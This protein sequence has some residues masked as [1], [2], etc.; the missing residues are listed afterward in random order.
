MHCVH[1]HALTW[2]QFMALRL[3]MFNPSPRVSSCHTQLSIS[4]NRKVGFWGQ[5]PTH[6]IACPSR[7]RNPLYLM[8]CLSLYAEYYICLEELFW[9]LT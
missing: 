3:D 6:Y 1:L 2:S 8:Y 5:K 7:P 4:S 9:C